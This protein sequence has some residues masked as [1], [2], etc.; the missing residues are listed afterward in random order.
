MEVE[1]DAALPKMRKQ[2]TMRA[3]QFV[4][5]VGRIVVRALR[6]EGDETVK[7]DVISRYLATETAPESRSGDAIAVTPENYRF[8]YQGAVAYNTRRAYVFH[9]TPKAKRVGLFDGEIWLDSQTYLPLRQWGE[10]VKSPSIFVRSV[11]FVRDYWIMENR[12]VPR[13]MITTVD[14]RLVGKAE[15]TVWFDN[16]QM[17]RAAS[18]AFRAAGGGRNISSGVRPSEARPALIAAR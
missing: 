1:I 4:P 18:E 16:V 9:V 6:F 13:R 15:M 12:S 7:N 14:T 11:Y 17:G 10:L 5:K 3:L 8:Q 2:G